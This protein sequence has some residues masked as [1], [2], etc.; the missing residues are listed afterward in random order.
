M[1]KESRDP[2]LASAST[3][4]VPR[5]R[6][7]ILIDR[8]TRADLG[9][10]IEIEKACYPDPWSEALFLS[11][12][13]YRPYNCPLA[14]RPLDAGSSPLPAEEGSLGGSGEGAS[15]RP[16]LGFVIT[17]LLSTEA[18][19]LNIAVDPAYQR[20]GYGRAL[21][22][23]ILNHAAEREESRA[24][25]EVRESNL[26]AQE[27]YQSV[28]FQVVGRRKNYYERRREDALIMA[29]EPLMAIYPRP[30]RLAKSLG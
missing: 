3:M 30:Y 7:L 9:R 19:I 12:V 24:V 28:G 13:S 23:A 2:S 27:L 5:E 10:L 29:V 25:L 8:P 14:A 15:E 16:L 11:E 22:Y 21:L 26:R 17:H 6:P 20:R 1:R 18:H 4:H